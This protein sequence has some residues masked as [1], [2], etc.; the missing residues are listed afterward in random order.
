LIEK[1]RSKEKRFLNKNENKT[2]K[3]EIFKDKKYHD[4]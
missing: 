4:N 2:I 1:E 3:M